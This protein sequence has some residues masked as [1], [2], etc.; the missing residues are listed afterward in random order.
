MDDQR[1]DAL[2]RALGS[3]S[4]RRTIL[5]ALR[6]VTLGGAL[7]LLGQEPEQAVAKKNH[8]RQQKKRRGKD[9]AKGV[10]AQQLDDECP[11]KVGLCHQSREGKFKFIQVCVD[12]VP[13]HAKHGDLVACPGA[14]VINPETCTCFCPLVEEDCPEGW[15][16]TTNTCCGLG[17]QA[18]AP[19][20]PDVDAVS[21]SS[22][23]GLGGPT[24][25]G[26]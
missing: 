11:A 6:A 10:R 12:A 20:C 4:S 21:P 9:R 13:A 19:P 14:G 5:T 16:C 7:S 22:A 24:A 26:I 8:A 17:V 3:G 18:C 2:V 15:S 23:Q 25:G 1:F